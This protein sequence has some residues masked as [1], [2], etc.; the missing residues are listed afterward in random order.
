MTLNANAVF[1]IVQN[2]VNKVT[3]VSFREGDRPNSPPPWIRL[4][5]KPHEMVTK[6]NVSY[7]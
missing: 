2:M 5:C 6:I 1:R 4:D 3:F 7:P